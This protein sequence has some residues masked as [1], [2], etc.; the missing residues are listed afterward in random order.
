MIFMF[1]LLT[2]LPYI[3]SSPIYLLGE[4]SAFDPTNLQLGK[5]RPLNTHYYLS[6]VC[7][8]VASMHVPIYKILHN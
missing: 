6:S 4:L 1:L 8:G 5:L 3:M 7:S 2:I